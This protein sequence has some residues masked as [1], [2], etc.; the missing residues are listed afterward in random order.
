MPTP[1]V[2]M[3]PIS[4][5]DNA[6]PPKDNFT[7]S[8]RIGWNLIS[9]MRQPDLIAGTTECSS[10]KLQMEQGTATPTLHP[11]KLLALAYGL[12]PDIAKRLHP[13]RHKLVV[14]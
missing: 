7:S 8:I 3:A 5:P 13:T 6:T 2:G 10:C 4:R 9:R 11:L 12:M 14:S 1:C